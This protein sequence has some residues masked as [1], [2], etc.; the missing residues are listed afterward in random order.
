MKKGFSL[1]LVIIIIAAFSV[2]A[3]LFAKI[4]YNYYGSAHA[5]LQREQAFYLAEAGLEKGKVEL[6]HNPNWY[7]DLPYYPA[8]NVT[9]LKNYAVGQTINL[10]DGFFKVVREKD[11]DRLY[12]IGQKGKGLVVLKITFSNPPLKTLSWVEL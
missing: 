3:A 12:A 4:V 2:M 8:D 9:W 5:L 1:I 10:G 7:T 6:A 11:K